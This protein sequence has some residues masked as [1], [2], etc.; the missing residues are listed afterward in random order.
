MTRTVG[1]ERR[2]GRRV[3]VTGGDERAMR[4]TRAKSNGNKAFVPASGLDTLIKSFS[5]TRTRYRLALSRLYANERCAW[6]A[7]VARYFISP[8]KRAARYRN[9]EKRRA[10]SAERVIAS[11]VRQIFFANARYAARA[12]LKPPTRRGTTSDLM[13]VNT[14][15]AVVDN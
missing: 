13:R 8:V 2:E 3:G 1:K 4:Y 14:R 6:Y 7:N 10:A 9:R 15:P 11:R 12:T 5:S